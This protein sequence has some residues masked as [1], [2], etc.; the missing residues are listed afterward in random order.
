M[1]LCTQTYGH[2]ANWVL[3]FDQKLTVLYKDILR[4]DIQ[5]IWNKI[6]LKN[7]W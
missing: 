3:I 5:V 2:Y 6:L 4:N 7:F 1:R